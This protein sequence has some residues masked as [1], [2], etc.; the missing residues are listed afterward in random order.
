MSGW[1]VSKGILIPYQVMSAEPSTI[2][3]SHLQVTRHLRN[4]DTLK[5]CSFLLTQ[6][7]ALL[8]RD[9]PSVLSSH[10]L[11]PHRDIRTAYNRPRY[12][13]SPTS[14]VINPQTPTHVRADVL[15][16]LA[17][18]QQPCL[19][20]FYL[21]LYIAALLT[22]SHHA[23]HVVLP[24]SFGFPGWSLALGNKSP[25]TSHCSR[26]PVRRF[27]IALCATP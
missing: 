9:M 3:E 27:R 10:S 2:F 12:L 14:P 13:W 21:V 24:A 16:R 15:V 1:T 5:S 11:F 17:C 6:F 23:V 8:T 7:P 19:S 18:R 26:F 22:P 20:R 25:S 4:H